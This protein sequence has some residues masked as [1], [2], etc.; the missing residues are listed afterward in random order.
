[1]IKIKNKKITVSLI[2]GIISPPLLGVLVAS[3]ATAPS[4]TIDKIKTELA[5]I[6][7][8]SN[9]FLFLVYVI[10]TVLTFF[11]QFLWGKT[12]KKEKCT[13][14]FVKKILPPVLLIGLIISVFQ[15]L[16]MV[17]TEYINGSVLYPIGQYIRC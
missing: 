4:S 1:M 7:N 8:A 12:G 11:I 14:G 2:L 3:A 5:H 10:G 17:S 6:E 15:K 9:T 13:S 16:F